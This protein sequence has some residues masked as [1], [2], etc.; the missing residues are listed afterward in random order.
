MSANP[1]KLRNDQM[2]TY[3]RARSVVF[4]KTKEAF[5]G[6]S[7]MAGG[8]PLKVNGIRIHTSEALYQS[9]RFPHMPEVQ[10]AILAQT[11]PMTAKMKGKPH[12]S[13]S[14]QDWDQVRVKIMRWCLRVKLA[15]NYFKFSSLLMETGERPIVEESRRD[16]FWGA[17]PIDKQTL[18]GMNVLGR[19]LME[20][21]EEIK[22]RERASLLRVEPLGIP[23]F[24]IYGLPIQT[25]VAD[26]IEEGRKLAQGSDKSLQ[27]T[28]LTD[29]PMQAS[30]FG[31]H[32]PED[33][34]EPLEIATTGATT[35]SGLESLKRSGSMNDPAVIKGLDP[36]KFIRARRP[37][38]F[39]DSEHVTKPLLSRE[40]LE[41]QLDTLTSR[42]QETEFEYFCRRLVEKEI[43]P[44]LRPQT[45]PTGGGDSKVDSETIPVSPEI[46]KLWIGTNPEAGNERWAFAFS[47][48]KTWQAKARSDIAGIANTKRSYKRAYFITN[49]F[50]RDKDRAALE[51]EL[52]TKYEIPVHILDRSW[53]VKSVIENDRIQIAIEALGLAGLAQQNYRKI[54]PRDLERQKELEELE[55]EIG[56]PD[57]YAGAQYQ[58]AEDCLRAAF[59]ARAMERPRTEIEGLFSRAE[60]IAEQVGHH[61]QQLRIAY[62]RAW[63]A[64]WW[65]NDV[66]ELNRLYG[67]VEQY[68]V[69]SMQVDDLELLLNLWQVLIPTVRKGALDANAAQIEA[70]TKKLKTEFERLGNDRTRPNN[71]LQARTDRLQIELNDVFESRNF[72]KLDQVW[73]GYQQIVREAEHLGDYPLERLARLI[74][75]L[76]DLLPDSDAFDELFESVVHLLKMQRSEGEGG[77]ALLKRGFQ[78]IKKKKPYDAIRLF[79]RAQESLIKREYR[80]ELVSAL[81]GCSVAYQQ[82]G[83]LWAARNSALSAAERCLAFYHEDGKIVRPVLPCLQHLIWLEIQL[84]RIPRILEVLELTAVLNPHLKLEAD[85]LKKL[86]EERTDQ[87][88]ILGLLLL[89]SSIAQLREMEMLPD[90]L[91]RLGMLHSK[92]ALLYALGCKSELRDEGFIPSTETEARIQETF[93]AWINQPSA[94]EVPEKPE[95]MVDKTI[96]FRSN[97]LGCELFASVENNMESIYL[98]EA[99]LGG[100]EAFLATSL[101]A[102]IVP[103]RQQAKINIRTSESISRALT[104]NVCN[105]D[106]E[107]V[108]EIVQSVTRPQTP[109]ERTAYRD[110]LQEAIVRI[111]C[112]IAIIED[113]ESYFHRVAG[114]ERAFGRALYFADIGIITTNI[115]GKTPHLRLTDW[116]SDQTLKRYRV[117]RPQVWNSELNMDAGSSQ[118]K[119]EPKFGKGPPPKKLL[120]ELDS[121]KHAQR[122]ILS[123][124]DVPLWDKAKWSATLY[125]QNPSKDPPLLLGLGFKD[126]EAARSIFTAWRKQLGAIDSEDVLRV[127]IITGVD[128]KRPFSYSVVIGT[129][130]KF[131]ADD[132]EGKFFLMVSRINRMTP[133]SSVNLDMFLDRFKIIGRYVIAPAHFINANDKGP[134]KILGDVCIEKTSLNVRPAWQIGENDPDIVGVQPDD[135]PI[136]PNDVKNPPILKALAR[137]KT[138]MSRERKEK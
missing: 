94:K 78:K 134:I 46:S 28:V 83:L 133:S 120:A 67:V 85:R 104:T 45:G 90:V 29:S 130:A 127:S 115:F 27:P 131:S 25:V 108:V 89:K 14:R 87:D 56:D 3:D 5:G 92:M 93:A 23:D 98:V 114:E 11:S 84:G 107:S 111:I 37:E 80:E 68:A 40:L 124:I 129:N 24:L 73:A 6:L 64:F 57:R 32:L 38:L 100:I 41:L 9:C 48:K 16:D 126:I 128:K 30:L 72:K 52:T 103:Y 49:Q 136:I 102:R 63:T 101:D 4:M 79:G 81:A 19:L 31:Q 53:I 15:Q 1:N 21:R 8:F 26:G 119:G 13:N 12:R 117:N 10:R 110:Q 112:H 62:Q 138:I 35:S 18:F 91:E 22:I 76:G 50:A 137:R 66:K 70:R 105:V 2:R 77:A 54:G 20:L 82:A 122:R 61:Q 51:D 75:E 125:A 34:S 69:G 96:T 118:R 36:A 7:N 109:E 60:R 113:V 88:I 47:A 99:L 58:L 44:N 106:G 116:V 17:K 59:L 135:D 74:E 42:K 86:S 33:R 97:V 123:L 43:C 121:V 39:S 132:P 55:K 71:A 65:Y 95:L